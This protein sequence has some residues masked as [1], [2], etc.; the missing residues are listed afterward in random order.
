MVTTDP[1][2]M[3]RTLRSPALRFST[4]VAR[5]LGLLAVAAAGWLETRYGL[6]AIAAAAVAAGA[7]VA[8]QRRAFGVM[9]GVAVLVELNGIPGVDVNPRGIFI[10]RLQDL[11][12]VGILVGSLYV[13]ASGKVAPRSSLQRMLYVTSFSLAGWWI[14][15]WARTAAFDGVPTILAARFS[16]DFLFFALTLPLLCDV[17][18]TYPRLRRQVF[19]TL[20]AGGAVFA[21]AEIAKSGAHAPVGFILHAHLLNVVEGTTRVYSPMNGLIRAAFALSCGALILARTPRLR[22]AAAVPAL[23]FGVAMLLQLTRAAYFGLAVGF[24]AAGALW[25]FRRGP[26][27]GAVRRQLVVVPLVAICLLSL[28]AAVSARERHVLSTASTRA[29]AGFSDF[30]STSGTV[31]TRVDLANEMLSLLG[32]NWLVGLGFIHPDAHYYTSLPNGSIRNGDVGVLNVLMV[33]GAV[34]AILLYLPLLLVLRALVRASPLPGSRGPG[35]EWLRLGASIW[36]V[37]VVAS[38]ITLIDLFTLS[39]LELSA[40]LLAIAASVAVGRAPRSRPV[41][42]Q[43]GRES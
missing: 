32:Q 11:F 2:G 15:T 19:W 8:L 7:A 3:P 34:G 9:L 4:G 14:V 17:F 6:R 38:S 42:L 29:L 25:W 43:G 23:L 30:S 33:M 41:E 37:S 13:V 1:V 35:D 36:I 24:V 21:L 39:G 10:S 28:G 26:I 16:R 18:V 40:C 12:A 27:R 20:G 22:R 5:V 31:Q